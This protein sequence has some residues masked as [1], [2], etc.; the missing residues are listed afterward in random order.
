MI[1]RTLVAA[2]SVVV[3][4]LGGT[5]VGLLV[6]LAWDKATANDFVSNALL[7]IP[8]FGLIGTAVMLAIGLRLTR[9]Q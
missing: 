3:G 7:T 2:L 9:S 6:G 1:V 4:W 8:L 5:E